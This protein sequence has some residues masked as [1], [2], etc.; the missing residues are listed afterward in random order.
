MAQA[1]IYG[2][3]CTNP[4]CG[5]LFKMRYPG[6]PGYFKVTCPHCKT[7]VTVKMPDPDL[8][9]GGAP[10]S[11]PYPSQQQPKPKE[12]QAPPPPP[13]PKELSFPDYS[14]APVMDYVDYPDGKSS[15]PTE[16]EVTFTCPHCRTKRMAYKAN[17]SGVLK[18]TCPGCKGPFR[19]TFGKDT[20][21]I[22][23]A[24]FNRRQ[25]MLQQVR[26]FRSNRNF[27][28]PLGEHTVGR[29]DAYK[30]SSISIKGDDA[31][32]R[33]SLSIKCFISPLAGYQYRLRVLHSSNPVYVGGKRLLDGEEI[34]L[35]FGDEIFLGKTTFRFLI[36]ENAPKFAE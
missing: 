19:V 7:K 18:F 34:Y 29:L 10:T 4:E 8:E 1:P 6:K 16:E 31:M 2:F 32:S 20:L 25:G 12:Q 11:A 30:P 17:K 9:N 36:D 5:K 14:G 22:N 15:F 13:R 23:P 28:L 24:D 21:L 27:P 35:K 3:N 26:R 33:Q